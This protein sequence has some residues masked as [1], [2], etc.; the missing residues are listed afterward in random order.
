MTS[1]IDRRLMLDQ[2]THAFGVTARVGMVVVSER[3]KVK[4]NK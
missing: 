4:P 3:G 2:W 1:V